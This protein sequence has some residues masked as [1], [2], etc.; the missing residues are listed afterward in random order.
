MKNSKL[1]YSM[2]VSLGLS[3]CGPDRSSTTPLYT[4]PAITNVGTT[5]QA[6]IECNRPPQKSELINGIA[7]QDD[8]FPSQ[9]IFRLQ[10]L[11]PQIEQS[12]ALSL[13]FYKWR[14]V[15][16]NRTQESHP[17]SFYVE[18]YYS[19]K[20]WQPFTGYNTS[21][22]QNFIRMM[23]QKLNGQSFVQ[24][25]QYFRLVFV[26]L[27]TNWQ[28]LNIQLINGGTNVLSSTDFLLPSFEADPAVYARTHSSL[29]SELHPLKGVPT[30][31][32]ATQ[33]QNLC[34]GF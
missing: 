25:L 14:A 19:D 9:I 28:A 24:N 2:M 31:Q 8:Q 34:I 30:A 3:A 33:A 17:I 29:L 22:D 26:G 32:I 12:N 4:D 18:A 27:E 21:I 15:G 13:K 11:N 23:N 16:Q 7:G 10:S 1:L 20:G 5:N 6:L